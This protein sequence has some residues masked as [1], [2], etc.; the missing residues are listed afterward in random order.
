M[1]DDPVSYTS[2]FTTRQKLSLRMLLS[3]KST[4]FNWNYNRKYIWVAGKL[5]KKDEN[6]LS[7][8]LFIVFITI[9]FRKEKV[10]L[11]FV[12]STTALKGIL[13]HIRSLLE[14]HATDA[15]HIIHNRMHIMHIVPCKHFKVF[16]MSFGSLKLK[17]RNKT[18]CIIII[19]SVWLQ[20]CNSFVVTSR[21]RVRNAV[22]SHS[23]MT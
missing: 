20:A 3:S 11:Y 10:F 17:S 1:S 21:E 2:Y 5:K 19:S 16:F 8:K 7:S 4:R 23:P 18:R 14:E 22:H 15:Y 9:L 12:T 6:S 13:L